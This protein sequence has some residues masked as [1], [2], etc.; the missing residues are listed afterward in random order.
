MILVTGFGPYQETNNASGVLVQSLKNELTK[1]L[2]PL[3]EALAFEVI[4]CD[5]TSRD[6]EHLT[7]EAQLSELLK[8]YQPGLCVHTGQAPSY[9]KLT[10]EKIA[11]N[12]FMQEIIDPDRP[13]AYWSTLPGIDTLRPAL[14][15]Q[16]IP[17][18]YSF[19]CGQHLCNHI[20]FS[21]RYFSET[22]GHS[23]ESG[24]IHVP[25][26]PEQ[27][28]NEHRD[29]PF[30]PLDMSRKALSIIINHVANA[31]RHI[32]SLNSDVPIS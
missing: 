19:Y 12:S 2:A 32:L 10:I 31:H 18:C 27:V 26:L 3:Q 29:S 20:L 21:S 7:L 22:N 25:L 4:T 8:R 1:E 30:M 11:I 6:T 15:K 17:A 28:T 13:V 9:N 24:F 5:D 23:H 14:E 16:G